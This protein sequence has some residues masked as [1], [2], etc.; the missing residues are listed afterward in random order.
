LSSVMNNMPT[1]LVSPLSIDVSSA[2]GAFA[3]Q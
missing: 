1:V 2:Q 3:N